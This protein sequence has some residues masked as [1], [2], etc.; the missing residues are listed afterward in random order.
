MFI[1]KPSITDYMPSAV[2]DKFRYATRIFPYLKKLKISKDNKTIKGSSTSRW[3][4]CVRPFKP[5]DKTRT[6]PVGLVAWVAAKFFKKH[7]FSN[8]YNIYFYDE[9]RGGIGTS[10]GYQLPGHIITNTI[11]L[12]EE[13]EKRVEIQA[14][15][16]EKTESM[17]AEKTEPTNIEG[18]DVMTPSS[19]RKK[20]FMPNKPSTPARSRQNS[21]SQNNLDEK[22]ASNVFRGKQGKDL[23]L[24]DINDIKEVMLQI[25]KSLDDMKSNMQE[26]EKTEL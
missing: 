10:I 17:K 18:L 24:G 2:K 15:Q 16:H 20:S 11:K 26:K 25:I 7:K 13:R 3:K 6:E 12:L 1:N 8:D 14:M 21:L 5:K 4:L 19:R 23:D 9:V 22:L